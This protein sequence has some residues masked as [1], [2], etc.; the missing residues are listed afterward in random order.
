[1]TRSINRADSS[2]ISVTLLVFVIV[3]V[4]GF[5]AISSFNIVESIQNDRPDGELEFTEIGENEIEVR[6][7]EN[8][9]MNFVSIIMPNGDTY[10]LED[11]GESK[12]ITINESGYINAIG[13]IEGSGNRE[14]IAKYYPENIR[15]IEG[16]VFF[17]PPLEDVKVKLERSG[18]IVLTQQT[19]SDGSFGLVAPTDGT[20]DLH[21]KDAENVK[22]LISPGTDGITI[23]LKSD[24]I[25]EGKTD[26][27]TIADFIMSGN[28]TSSTPYEID[29]ASDLQ[30]SRTS[31]SAT[32]IIRDD[33]DASSTT[34]A[35]W[36]G[37]F[38]YIGNNTEF[39]GSVRTDGQVQI[40]NLEMSDSDVAVFENVSS[41]ASIDDEN[42]TVYD[43]N[44]N[45]IDFVSNLI[46][47]WSI[48]DKVVTTRSINASITVGGDGNLSLRIPRV[49]EKNRS[50]MP[51]SSEEKY[52]LVLDTGVFDRGSRSAFIT[53]EDEE[54][55][56]PIEI[57]TPEGANS[58]VISRFNV[59]KNISS[60]NSNFDIGVEI[61][62]SG[63]DTLNNSSVTINPGD[64]VAN[65]KTKNVR[66]LDPGESQFITASFSLD[67]SDS[68]ENYKAT[69]NGPNFS[70]A[71]ESY[72]VTDESSGF[73]INNVSI[74]GPTI[75]GQEF[76]VEAKAVNTQSASGTQSISLSSNDLNVQDGSQTA[77]DSGESQIVRL[78]ST[79][80]LGS[81]QTTTITVS[82]DDSET[83]SVTIDRQDTNGMTTEITN[84]TTKRAYSQGNSIDLNVEVRNDGNSTRTPELNVKIINNTGEVVSNK[85]VSTSSLSPG[86]KTSYSPSFSSSQLNGEYKIISETQN[87]TGKMNLSVVDSTGVQIKN[88]SIVNPNNEAEING[89]LR[90]NFALVNNATSTKTSSASIKTSSGNSQASESY[91]LD[92]GET[93]RFRARVDL[94][95]SETTGSSS[96]T[97]NLNNDQETKSFTIVDS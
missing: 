45:E 56:E 27:D 14:L 77:L 11:A 71:T 50:V 49:D 42:V 53:M 36:N 10:K 59:P 31:K 68:F 57:V 70:E 79:T 13:E 54:E 82:N 1:M 38:E 37:G 84:P 74:V 76:I 89:T 90:I 8:Q 85:S 15:A 16:K 87:D 72:T 22:S 65:S 55:T 5:V 97:I 92:P 26:S 18:S 34:E 3:A 58:P 73:L 52:N 67:S 30:S 29:S 19:D 44:G 93:R 75:E 7:I 46:I 51:S 32:Y 24:I 41:S 40:K 23:Y 61:V 48:P 64:I 81:N 66:D 80:K 96:V 20:Y 43:P 39:N 86:S 60:Q 9:N 95:A 6:L 33:I 83:K 2:A 12:R 94:S 78:R 62:N 69:V 21:V 35:G 4:F 91:A 25:D 28:G 47:D 63:N 17:N 88:M